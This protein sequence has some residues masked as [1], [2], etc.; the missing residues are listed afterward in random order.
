MISAVADLLKHFRGYM[1]RF[2]A[3]ANPR[4]VLD[5][6]LY[7]KPAVR[8]VGDEIAGRLELQ[9]GSS[10]LMVGGIGSGKTTQLMH[11][12]TRLKQLPDT[13]ALYVDVSAEHDMTSIQPSLL[14][15]IAG[16]RLSQILNDSSE[17][18]VKKATKHFKERAHGFSY[19]QEESPPPDDY[20]DG[21]PGYDPGEIVYVP[22][23][24]SPPKTNTAY[25]PDRPHLAALVKA[26]REKTPN[27]SLLIDSLD[28]ISDL[29]SFEKL[30]ANDLPTFQ[31][32]GIGVVLVGPLRLLYGIWRP[33][34]ESFDKLYPVPWVDPN[35]RLGADFL[36]TVLQVRTTADLL[37]ENAATDL[38]KASGGVLRDLI[39]LARDAGE[40]A[41]LSGA[42]SISIKHVAAA[43]DAFGR[44][45]MLGL[46]TDDLATLQRVRTQAAFVP[47]TDNDLALLMSGRVLEYQNGSIHYAVK[48]L[49]VT[50]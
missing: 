42:R 32:L 20:D 24:L 11:V 6:G 39:G 44:T 4:T 5:R 28:R 16:L 23:I 49:A 36:K 30:I 40:E 1:S 26:V 31:S 35:T 19:Y 13:T 25:S 17:N 38:V 27:I 14:L 8:S 22:G 7:V 10:H 12:E 2:D 37:S 43:A 41:Y 47:T 3:A 33:L 21:D 34:A 29:T 50:G 18:S 9:P 46:N 45:R 48:Q 15:V